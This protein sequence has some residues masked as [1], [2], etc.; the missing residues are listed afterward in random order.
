M[1]EST[2]KS[3]ERGV[4]AFAAPVGKATGQNVKDAR[5]G[6]DRENER[7]SE[8]KIEAMSV[9]HLSILP[10]ARPWRPVDD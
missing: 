3:T 5:T 7:G 9:E 1:E 4:D 10:A 6:S 8:K 2:D